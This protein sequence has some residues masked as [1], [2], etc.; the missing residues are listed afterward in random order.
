MKSTRESAPAT[1]G[2]RIRWPRWYDAL[3]RV[4][5]LGREDQFRQRTVELAG[6]KTGQTVL[7]VGCGTGNLTMAA[8]SLAGTNGQVHGNDA[9]PE[10]IREAERKA[11][12][13]QLDI[14][15][16]VALIEQIPYPDHTFDVVLSSLMLHHLPRDLKRKGISEIARVLKSGCRLFAVDV[17]PPFMGNLRTVEEAMKLNGF[18]DIQRGRM[19][20]RTLWIPIHFLTGTTVTA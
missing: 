17:D 11:A 10:M 15:Y 14:R 13:R 1:K 6:I 9:A 7:D 18:V 20:F 4:H 19:K 5:F 16:Q 12:A 3:N 2:I 8:K